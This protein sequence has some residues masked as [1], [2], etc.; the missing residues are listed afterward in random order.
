MEISMRYQYCVKLTKKEEFI[1]ASPHL[2]AR[3]H[4]IPTGLIV[5][6]TTCDILNVKMQL[7]GNGRS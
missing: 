6:F 2:Q 4:D 7:T 5:K 1:L 3:M